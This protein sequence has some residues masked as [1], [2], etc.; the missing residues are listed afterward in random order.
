MVD[1]RD[2]IAGGILLA[3]GLCIYFISLSFPDLPEGYPGPSLFPQI[4]AI[5]LGLMGIA[6]GISAFQK[7]TTTKAS[8]SQNSG[9]RAPW[10]LLGG[11]GLIG[12]YPLL[13]PHLA[14][15]QYAW[16]IGVNPMF[17][18]MGGILFSFARLTQVP[19]KASLAVA[20]LGPLLVFGV[21]TRLLGVAL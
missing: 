11:L 14:P 1:Q 6:L 17:L 4:I 2:L 20:I 9:E 13:Y 21:F 3:L 7:P 15:L 18:V 19:L 5:G 10:R 16:G 8:T 12:I